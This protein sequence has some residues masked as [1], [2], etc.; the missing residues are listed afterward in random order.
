MN[1]LKVLIVDDDKTNRR[2]LKEIVESM[3]LVLFA[4]NGQQAIDKSVELQPDLILL[5]IV[6]PDISGFDVLN[7]LKNNPKVDHIPVVFITGKHENEI[8]ERGLRMGAIDFIT[9]P[10]HSGIVQARVYNHLQSVIQKKLLDH[11]A[12][13]DPLTSIPNRRQFNARLQ[14]EYL[15]ALESN[16]ILT[17]AIVDVDNFKLYNDHYGHLKGDQVLKQV[18]KAVENQVKILGGFVARFG[19]E[20]LVIL[21][22]NTNAIDASSRL[23]EIRQSVENLEIPHIKNISDYVTVSIGYSSA[24]ILQKGHANTIFEIADKY[25]YIAKSNGRNQVNGQTSTI[26]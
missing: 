18:A 21:M 14:Q 4:K 20:E 23:E 16:Q 22:P 3:A 1:D 13:I 25:L 10:F 9:K 26:K 17:L 2:V 5:D 15:H 24:N 6:M 19:G 7:Q 8:E 11:Y 12:Y